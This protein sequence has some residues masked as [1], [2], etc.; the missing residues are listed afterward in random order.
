[1]FSVRTSVMRPLSLKLDMVTSYTVCWD[2]C[3][4][5]YSEVLEGTKQH[6]QRW[7]TRQQTWLGTGKRDVE[8]QALLGEWGSLCVLGFL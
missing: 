6:L 7:P 5:L 8:A 1:M 3:K 4:V 2:H